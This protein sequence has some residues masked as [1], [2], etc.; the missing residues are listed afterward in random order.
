M[1]ETIINQSMLKVGTILRGTYRIDSYL[2]SGGFGNT[3]V[4][5]NIEF[6]ERVAIKE[7]FMKGVTHREENQTTVSVSNVENQDGFLEQKEKFKKEARRLRK[8]KNEHI[9]SV[10]DL[11]E[12]NGTAYYVMDYIDG[13]SLAERLKR[14]GSPL[15]EQ[16][17]NSILPQILDALKTVHDAGIWHLDLKPANIMIDKSGIVKLIDFGASKQLNAQKG[18]ATTSSAICFTNGYAPREQMEQN[19]DKFGP[20]TDIYA[21]GA[22]LYNIVTMNKPPLPS[23]I[24]DEGDGAFQ[25][26]SFISDNM[27]GFIIKLMTPNRNKRPRCINDVLSILKEFEDT[28]TDGNI[29]ED[30][31]TRIMDHNHDNNPNNVMP[32]QYNEIEKVEETLLDKKEKKELHAKPLSSSNNIE[33]S[34]LQNNVSPNNNIINEQSN[35][36]LKDNSIR[37]QIKNKTVDS[38]KVVKNDHNTRFI[39]LFFLIVCAICAFFLINHYRGTNS[40][41]LLMRNDSIVVILPKHTASSSLGSLSIQKITLTPNQTKIDFLNVNNGYEWATIDKNAYISDKKNK[42][43][44]KD[45]KGIEITPQKTYYKDEYENL[46][47]SLI[48]PPIP[49]DVNELDFIE[50][51]ESSWKIFNIDINKHNYK[52]R[53]SIVERIVSN[54]VYVKGGT[55]VMGDDGWVCSSPKFKVE[56]SDFYISKYEVTQKEWEVIYGENPSF[57]KGSNRPVESVEMYKCATFAKRLS[58]LSGKCFRLPTE[59]EW[60]YAARGGKY[61]SN[62]KYSGGNKLNEVAWYSDN[63]EKQTHI[64]GSK[65][66]NA[67]GLYDMSGNVWEWCLDYYGNYT[68]QTKKDPKGPDKGEFTVYRGGSYNEK[69]TINKEGYS[70]FWIFSRSSDKPSSKYTNVG[71]RLVMEK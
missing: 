55:F 26:P 2:S 18:G 53:D 56:L 4:A 42:Y 67:L 38:D 7:F 37:Q 43:Y 30:E 19:Y 31:V 8:L 29:I 21:L 3:Y 24:D 11:F 1:Q 12:E 51:N 9:V 34:N 10:H 47:F 63:S 5:S 41:K 65:E 62:F 17:V 52:E 6:D 16:E 71:F 28:A 68:P 69:E 60:E 32:G 33:N 57:F 15:T 58:E 49:S 45:A 20:W 70:D 27:K 40:D 48:F 22:T 44:L 66:P 25:F 36:V 54:M 59:A 35:V 46:Y 39:L 64:V 50:N 61:G 23:D 14:T 13:E